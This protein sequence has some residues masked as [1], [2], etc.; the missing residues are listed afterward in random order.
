MALVFMPAKI[1]ILV[2]RNFR[3]RAGIPSHIEIV[4]V[5]D[6]V[7]RTTSVGGLQTTTPLRTIVDLLGKNDRDTEDYRMP[8]S[9]FGKRFCPH[10]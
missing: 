6:I 2:R 8:S 3:K 9:P 1:Y 4:E 5:D 7:D 10:D